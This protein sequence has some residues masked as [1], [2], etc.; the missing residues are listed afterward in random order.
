MCQEICEAAASRVR[1]VDSD[2]QTVVDQYLAF[3]KALQAHESAELCLI[4]DAI[5]LDIGVGD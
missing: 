5:N 1:V 4:M 2:M 3:S